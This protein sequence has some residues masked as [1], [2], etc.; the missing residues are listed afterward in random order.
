MSFISRVLGRSDSSGE[1][2]LPSRDAS[3]TF[4]GGGGGGGRLLP[5]AA[6]SA[7]A[8]FLDDPEHEVAR[9]RIRSNPMCAWFLAFGEREGGRGRACSVSCAR[10]R[11]IN[12]P[13]PN[14]HTN[15]NQHLKQKRKGGRST[16]AAGFTSASALPR[17]RPP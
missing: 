3:V 16:A 2:L 12:S 9:A 1:P 6:A 17:R 15:P 11:S 5:P 13:P 7:G 8:S 4:G 10:G 14:K